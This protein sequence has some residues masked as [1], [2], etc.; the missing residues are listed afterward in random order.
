MAARLAT[1]IGT[2]ESTHPNRRATY[3]FAASLHSMRD[4]RSPA[5]RWPKKER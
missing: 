1:T 2:P 4:I 3:A 5:E